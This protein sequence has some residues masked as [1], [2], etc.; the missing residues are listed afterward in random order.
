MTRPANAALPLSEGAV[1]P[2]SPE[3]VL[4]P[5]N[6]EERRNAPKALF[7]ARSEEHNV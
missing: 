6:P 7:V 2:R 5:L 3:A 4:G 1:I